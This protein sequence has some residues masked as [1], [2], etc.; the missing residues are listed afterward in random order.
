M[1]ITGKMREDWDDYNHQAKR[2]GLK[3]KTLLEYVAYRKGKYNPKIKG[4]KSTVPEKYIRQI[5][6]PSSGPGISYFAK[7]IEEKR[8]TGDKLVGIGVLHKSNLV[9][10]FKQEDA[11]DLA[12]MRRN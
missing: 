8:Y 12:K 11:E 2:L 9:P 10:V 6:A 5:D 7:S 1:K 3:P 4:H